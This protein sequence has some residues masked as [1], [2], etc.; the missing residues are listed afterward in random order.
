MYQSRDQRT[1]ARELRKNATP[2]ERRLWW[3]LKAGKL[4]VTFRRQAA[5]GSY[6]VDV[7]C[8]PAKLI[9]ELDGPQ[10]L[11]PAAIE[12]DERRTAWLAA[13]GFHIIRFRNQELDEDVQGVVQ[14]IARALQ[15]REPP[16][17]PLSPNPSPP[18]GGGPSHE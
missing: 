11:T 6:V 13:Q 16:K 1:F 15:E 14:G 4:G 7:V 18:R 8:F 3:F 5:I 17:S 9:I 10:H 2:A 12:H